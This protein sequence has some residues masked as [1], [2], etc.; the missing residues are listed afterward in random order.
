MR[1]IVEDIAILGA[2]L[3]DDERGVGDNVSNGESASAIGDELAVGVADE[4]AVR[5]RDKEL[6]IRDGSICYSVHLFYEHAALG[7]IAK[8]QRHDSVA[9]DFNAL[10]RIVENVAILSY[11]PDKT[12]LRPRLSPPVWPMLCFFGSHPF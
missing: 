5:I 9:L 1:G 3:L 10:R 7:L 12:Y 2:C 11:K 4:I 6:N 8:L